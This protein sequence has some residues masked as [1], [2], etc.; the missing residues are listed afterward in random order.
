TVSGTEPSQWCPTQTSEIFASDQPPLVKGY[1]LWQKTTI[2]TWT[3]LLAS[4][5]CNEFTENKLALNISDPWAIRW[6][7]NDSAGQSWASNNGFKEPI[8][9]APTKACSENDPRPLLSIASPDNGDL[10]DENPLDIYGQADAT[11]NFYMY[12]L[13][14]GR[15]DDPVEWEQIYKKKV[16]I[17]EPELIYEWDVN[18]IDSGII[19]LRLYME[20]TEDTY[21]ETRIRLDMQVPTPTPTPTET[22][23]ETPTPTLTPSPTQTPLPTLTPTASQTPMPTDTPTTTPVPIFTITPTSTP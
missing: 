1:D 14:Y 10:I 3:G 20:S 9:F 18:E 17:D 15:G 11:D 13:E 2:D 22:P 21:A 7:K 8:F 12:R 16:P 6:V 4:P 23:T 5:S 19:T